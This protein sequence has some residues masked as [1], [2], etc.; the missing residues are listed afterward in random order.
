MTARRIERRRAAEGVT[1]PETLHPLLRR[2]YLA[3]GVSAAADLDQSLATLCDF[4][5]L[6]GLAEAVKLVAGCLRG[7]KRMLIVGDFD[8]DGATSSA[9]GVRALRKF[10][11]A[12]VDYLVPNR[13]EYG[14]G[15]TP[16]IVRLAAE[17]HPDLIITVD[18]GISSHAGVSAARAAGMRVLVTDHHVPGASLPDADAIVNP[19]VPG[20]GFPSKCLA[21]VGVMFYLLMALRAHLR[22]K[23]W[24]GARGVPEPKLAEFL[25]IVALG[26]V[27]DLVP[28]DHNN[29]VLVAQGLAR[30][31]ARRSVAG[32]QALLEI[33][34]REATR[35]TVADLAFGVAP[36]L[37]AA[38]RL[39]DMSLGIE[40]LL[41]DDPLRAQMLA[42]QL[43]E[44]NHQR[45]EI[46][47]QMQEEALQVLERMG[48]NGEDP[49]LPFGLCLFREE[50]H[51]GVVGLVASRIK[52]QTH[53]PVIAFAR[54]GDGLLKGSARSVKG[55]HV[56][57]VLA[58]VAT[59]YPGLIDKFGGH[60][61][62]AGLSLAEKHFE[63]FSS[64]FDAE[65]RRHMTADDL[66]DVI[67]S[68]GELSRQYLT[69]ECAERLRSAGPWGQGFP[70]PVF[71][72]EFRLLSRRVVGTG[73]LKMELMEPASGIQVEA[74]AFRQDGA[75]LPAD[76]DRV[77]L[78]YRPDVN[79]YRG[80]QR[81]QLLVDFI[82]PV[83]P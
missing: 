67:Y 22:A 82:E 33:A 45:R 49:T 25:D 30:I 13:F 6:S 32:I 46:E 36:R 2:L 57:D 19:N 51:Q 17:R 18:N 40:L 12:Q 79:H 23:G 61:M 59:Q 77:R 41:T 44:L 4:H 21:G 72:G 52:D 63:E 29:R 39:T 69:I 58:A 34:R 14:Y 60:A 81:L 37:N 28:L 47:A 48:F 3:R 71:D 50:W 74:I 66:T 8:A 53:R 5:G 78:V 15:L 83:V 11:A 73:H 43:D 35:L 27:A 62:A 10:G 42:A 70:E 65:V 55:V 24:F 7:G 20:D 64:A 31:R 26:T 9:L 16:E 38:G 56:R 54:A 80:E 75:H 68:D 76:C 1:L